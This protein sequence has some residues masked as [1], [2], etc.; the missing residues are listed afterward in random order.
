MSLKL[1]MNFAQYVTILRNFRTSPTDV[2][3]R[4][5]CIALTL[6]GLDE[7]PCAEKTSPKKVSES[8]WSSHF[9]GE[10]VSPKSASCHRTACRA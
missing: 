10:I 6:A 1:G 4:A 8:L 3:G 5:S 9:S 7:T 2:G